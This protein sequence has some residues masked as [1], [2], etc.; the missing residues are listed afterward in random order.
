ML[1]AAASAL[2]RA[3]SFLKAAGPALSKYGG[4]ALS[5]AAGL[6]G[7]VYT[8]DTLKGWMGGSSEDQM[9]A[10][11]RSS[12]DKFTLEGLLTE[13]TMLRDEQALSNVL[14][15]MGEMPDGRRGMSQIMG[16]MALQEALQREAP[17]LQAA[18]ERRLRSG[19]GLSYAELL[20]RMG[21]S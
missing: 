4:A 3:L 11:A 21:V 10:A 1:A 19:T 17:R 20:D 15:Q 9:N 7:A 12:L 2:P 8:A 6:G 18:A 14:G 16:D 5:G 13:D